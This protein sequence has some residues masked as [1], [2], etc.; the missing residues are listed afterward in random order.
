[1]QVSNYI[2]RVVL[3]HFVDSSLHVSPITSHPFSIALSL[4]VHASEGY[5]QYLIIKECTDDH[6]EFIHAVQ[7]FVQLRGIFSRRPS[8]MDQRRKRRERTPAS[9]YGIPTTEGFKIFLDEWSRIGIHL[10]RAHNCPTVA[11]NLTECQSKRGQPM[12]GVIYDSE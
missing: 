10:I 6:Q 3:A 8:F 11:S 1:M 2:I 9:P 12:K 5:F 4:T 7:L